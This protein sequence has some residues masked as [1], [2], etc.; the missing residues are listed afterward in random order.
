MEARSVINSKDEVCGTLAG[1]ISLT[2]L[3]MLRLVLLHQ[4]LRHEEPWRETRKQSES[5]E[6]SKKMLLSSEVLVHLDP[7]LEIRGASDAF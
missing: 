3:G 5:F 1:G 4:L 6:K 7:K 2:K